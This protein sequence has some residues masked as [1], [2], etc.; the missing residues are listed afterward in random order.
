MAQADLGVGPGTDA[1]AGTPATSGDGEPRELRMWLAARTDVG[2]TRGKLAAQSG[3]AF[4]WHAVERTLVGDPTFAAYMRGPTTKVVVAARN[5]HALRRCL[6]EARAAD[7]PA[8]II[9]DAGR[10]E[11]AG[12]TATVVAFGPAYREHLPPYLARLR[13]LEDEDLWRDVG[14]MPTAPGDGRAGP[15]VLA[16]GRHL[17]ADEPEH[18][19]F[20]R[21][22][23][24][25]G[26]GW[27]G[28]DLARGPFAP[29]AWRPSPAGPR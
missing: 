17:G 14:T 11:F 12:P 27:Y 6:E 3:H 19:R 4:Q 22:V 5:E 15:V 21:W 23:G 2:M 9:T 10:T 1:V 20:V 26:G 13:K 18:A 8:V 25:D 28:E 29:S 16:W 24:G 7:V